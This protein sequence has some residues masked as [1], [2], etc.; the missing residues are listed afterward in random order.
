[1]NCD[2]GVVDLGMKVEIW[3]DVAC[4][5]CF[6]GKRRFEAALNR[7]E[8]RDHVEVTWRS[9]ELDPNAP[10][11]RP[12]PYVQRLAA[13]YGMGVEQA[14]A[15]VDTMV[16]V[17][18]SEGIE[19][20]FEHA[21]PGNTFDAHRLLHLAKERGLQNELKGRLMAANFSEGVAV[22]DRDALAAVATEVGLGADELRSVLESDRYAAEVRADERRAASLGIDAVPFFVLDGKYGVAGAR[23][24]DVFLQILNDVWQKSAPAP[25][26]AG[27]DDGPAAACEGDACAVA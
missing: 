18:R 20:D 3:S 16:S 19:F 24:S 1:M 21:Q 10:Q 17:G 26:P 5:W 4:P 22:G 23:S 14:Q 12:G 2:R 9:F 15:M 27:A 7:F 6:V 13:K 25:V 8:H 11:R